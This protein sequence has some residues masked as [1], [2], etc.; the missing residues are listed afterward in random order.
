MHR[1][2]KPLYRIEQGDGGTSNPDGN[3]TGGTTSTANDDK[4]ITFTP[5]TLAERL[6]RAVPT[7][8]DDMKAK[9]A[10]YDE[11]EE[12]N[13][14]A[15]EKA[16]GRVTSAE[17]ERDQAK[18]EALR[19]RIAA[20]HGVS[21]EDADLFL[22]GADEATLTKQAERLTDRIADRKKQGNHVPKEGN[23]PASKPGPEREFLAQVLGQG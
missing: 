9:A 22:T 13:K 5:K 15:L 19:L 23:N 11:Q 8:Y 12:A 16:T 20:K 6:A 18:A 1:T 2:L 17:Q 21:D 7:D 3:N 4:T 14:S 10:K